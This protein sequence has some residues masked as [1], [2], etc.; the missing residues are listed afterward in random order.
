MCFTLSRPLFASFYFSPLFFFAQPFFFFFVFAFPISKT[1]F[2][3]LVQLY[4]TVSIF[5]FRFPLH[6]SNFIYLLLPVHFPIM[7]YLRHCALLCVLFSWSLYTPLTAQADSDDELVILDLLYALPDETVEQLNVLKT[8]MMIGFHANN[9][10]IRGRKI[11]FVTKA[12]DDDGSDVIATVKEVLAREPDVMAALGPYGDTRTADILKDAQLEEGFELPKD[13]TFLAPFTGGM[14]VRRWTPQLVFTR[15]DPD[16]EIYELV[17][18]TVN[19]VNVRRIGFMYL[20]GV[21]MGEEM[22]NTAMRRF[23]RLGRNDVVVYERAFSS[24][25]EME[26]FE[27]FADSSPEVILA[28]GAPGPHFKEFLTLCFTHPKTRHSVVLGVSNNMAFIYETYQALIKEGDDRV[29][30]FDG[31]ITCSTTNALPNYMQAKHIQL[32]HEDVALYVR[33]GQQS[34]EVVNSYVDNPVWGAIIVA[35]WIA[36]RSIIQML[37]IPV[38]LESRPIFQASLFDQRR[39]VIGEDLVIGDYGGACNSGLEMQGAACECNQ[40]GRMTMVNYFFTNGT[41]VSELENAFTYPLST[42]YST[43]QLVEL[44][45]NVLTFN[46]APSDDP[47]VLEAYAADLKT[48]IVALTIGKT[49]GLASGYS[50]NTFSLNSTVATIQQ[51]FSEGLNN[52]VYDLITCANAYQMDTEGM[53]VINPIA[54]RPHLASPDPGFIYLMPTLQQQIYVFFSYLI[55][56]INKGTTHITKDTGMHVIIKGL[57]QSTQATEDQ[58]V[59]TQKVLGTVEPTFSALEDERVRKYIKSNGVRGLRYPGTVKP[60]NRNLPVKNVSRKGVTG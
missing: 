43:N 46:P 25:F 32:F 28:V 60:V 31:H 27:E 1:S 12:A 36:A 21:N 37:D 40:G 45:I 11:R 53:L 24:Q 17:D 50:L 2:I 49:S 7:G 26:H 38:Y 47:A 8:G 41:A 56:V 57:G 15:A 20:S 39:Y 16:A 22:Y 4:I 58:F 59:L 9:N 35:G 5:F 19:R 14:A 48:V 30:Q 6:I 33:D 29:Q 10:A 23:T 34:A 54:H 18:Y 51:D 52:S 44:P 3:Y 42:C 13:L 55:Y